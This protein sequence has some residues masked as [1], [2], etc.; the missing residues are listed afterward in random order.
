MNFR[1]Q[2]SIETGLGGGGL[3]CYGQVEYIAYRF[4]LVM[5]NFLYL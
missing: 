4:H 2:S 5:F 3:Y 1:L